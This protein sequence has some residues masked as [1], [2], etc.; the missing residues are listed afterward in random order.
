MSRHE[1]LQPLD[2]ITTPGTRGPLTRQSQW[3]RND[4]G[5]N[6]LVELPSDK[7]FPEAV[8]VWKEDAAAPV[9]S[10]LERVADPILNRRRDH[11]CAEGDARGPTLALLSSQELLQLFA[12]RR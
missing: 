9:I 5:D 1:S 3:R 2:A 11:D 6:L 4:A 7:A 8:Y 12:S 10:A